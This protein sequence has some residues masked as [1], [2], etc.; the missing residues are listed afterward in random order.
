[1]QLSVVILHY[2]AEA[3][4][5]L[6]LQSV[7]R[8]TANI[9]SEIIVADNHSPGFDIS[10]WQQR[11]PGINFI[12]FDKNLGFGKGNNRAVSQARGTYTVLLNPDVVV[13]EDTFEKLLREAKKIKNPGILGVRL[14]DG[15]GRFL[16]ES[17][18]NF[19]DLMNALSKLTGLDNMLPFAPFSSYYN[20]GI[21]EDEKGPNPVSVGAFMFFKTQAFQDLGG[22]D[23]RYFMYGEDI[24][25]SRSFWE[26]GLRNYYFGN[27]TAVH[28]KGE[29]TPQ[30]A[31]Y[32]RHF[33]QASELYYKK[34]H[35][36][37][38]RLINP[39][40]RIFFLLHFF[41]A[42][43]KQQKSLRHTGRVYFISRTS[44]VPYGL[45]KTYPGIE[46]FDLSRLPQAPE[47][48]LIIFDTASLRFDEI[49]RT[50]LLMRPKDFFYRFWMKSLQLLIG[51]DDPKGKGTIIRY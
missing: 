18:R 23:E 12:R 35:P 29:S 38:A 14:I 32:R 49:I 6:C 46:L 2:D 26:T 19:P 9:T 42:K 24:D 39:L 43:K 28:F 30:T 45:Q 17:K 16:P 5:H 27:I 11:Y 34:Y 36:Y 3:F 31:E 50:M 33:I 47:G 40:I 10:R 21:N 22:F 48:S 7:I 1:M 4:L 41:F 13:A 15:R 25:L 20:R 37:S 8:A 44:E 51:S